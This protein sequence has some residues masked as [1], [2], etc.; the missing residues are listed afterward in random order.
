M[1]P[2]SWI[3]SKDF[4]QFLTGEGNFMNLIDW[5][6]TCNLYEEKQKCCRSHY[7]SHVQ[8]IWINPRSGAN[9]HWFIE[10]KNE[11]RSICI[12]EKTSIQFKTRARKCNVLVTCARG[13][14]NHRKWK[15]F[16]D[17]KSCETLVIE[18]LLSEILSLQLKNMSSKKHS[19]D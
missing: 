16:W 11:I 14:T 17:R 19:P 4:L 6:M 7:I 8:F 9:P 15:I 2:P 18:Y 5:T 3:N 13:E 10:L 12:Y 1:K